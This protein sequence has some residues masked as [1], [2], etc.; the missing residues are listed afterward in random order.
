MTIRD[1]MPRLAA[2]AALVAAALCLQGCGTINSTLSLAPG[3]QFV[4]GGGQRGAFKV[5]AENVGDTP[6][7]ISIRRDD[8]AASALGRLEPGRTDTIRFPAGTAAVVASA[9]ETQPASLR[10]RV[11]GDTDLGMRYEPSRAR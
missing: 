10:V 7:D 4:L 1:P 2:G 3:K 5:E 6:V 8:E 9:S 11:T